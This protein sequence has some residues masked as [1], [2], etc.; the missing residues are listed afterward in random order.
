[1]LVPSFRILDGRSPTLRPSAYV[2]GNDLLAFQP[3]IDWDITMMRRVA[4]VVG[5]G[6][7]NVRLQGQGMVAITTHYD[8]LALQVRP[9]EPVFTDPHA[10]VAWSGSLTPDIRTDVSLR[11]FMGRGSGESLQLRFEGE[12][13]LVLQPFEER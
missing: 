12:G 7:F 1:M 4:G 10:T 13:W 6:L 3:S 8:P 2:N 9:G 5:G 11:T